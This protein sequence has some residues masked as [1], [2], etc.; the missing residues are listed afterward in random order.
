MPRNIRVISIIF[1]FFASLTASAADPTATAYTADECCGTH[2]PYP[3]R[4]HDTAIPDSLTAV[5]INHVGRH[6][7]RYP[8]S[9]ANTTEVLRTLHRADSAEIGRASCRERV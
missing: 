7:A 9:A 5:F 8:S 4:N 1:A 6:G 3:E 2:I